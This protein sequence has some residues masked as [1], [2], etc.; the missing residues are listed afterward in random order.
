MSE[1]KSSGFNPESWVEASVL[2][3]LA[4]EDHPLAKTFLVQ[5][6]NELLVSHALNRAAWCDVTAMAHLFGLF[7]AHLLAKSDAVKLHVSHQQ[8]DTCSI[9]EVTCIQ[10][11]TRIYIHLHDTPFMLDTVRNYLKQSKLTIYAQAHTTVH[12]KR[13]RTGEPVALAQ[14]DTKGY[15]REMVI[16]IL[17]ETV[18]DKHLEQI[19]DELQAVLTSVKRSVD[20]F[21]AMQQQVLAQALLLD[22]E[23]LTE[24]ASFFRWMADENF[25]FMGT[26]SIIASGEQLVVDQAVPSFGVL[27]GHDSTALLDRIMPGM[28]QEIEK[29][30]NLL[31][32]RH[33]QDPHPKLAIEYC[34]HG[35][36]IIYAAEGVDFVVL[37]RPANPNQATLVLTLILG[38]FSRTGLAS[39]ASNVPILSRRLEKTLQLSGFTEG[40]YLHHEFRS[41]YDRMPLRELLYSNSPVITEQIKEIL[42]MEGDNDVR[43]LARLGH[44]G[45]YVAVLTT[46]ARSRYHP[47]LQT[48]IAELYSK[49]LDFPI[50]SINST[51]NGT[52][53]TVVCY[54]NHEPDKPFGFNRTAI[55]AQVR[56]LVMTWEDH[57]REELLT[58]Y[59][60][61][62]AFQLCTR[63]S[64]TF[65]ILYKEATPA[66]QAVLDIEMLEKLVEGS[67]FTSRIAHYP[68][69]QVY[70]KLYAHKPAMLTKIVQTFDNFGISCL[71]EFSTEVMLEA[72]KPLTIQ[73]FEVGGSSAQISALLNRAELFCEALNAVQEDAIL[74]DKLN[75]LVLIQGFH[76]KEVM[77][78]E[79]LRQ[80]L[81]QIRP[82]LSTK[83][84]NRVLLEH[85]PLTKRIL[86][87]FIARFDPVGERGRKKRIKEILDGLEEGL[88][89]VANL[90]DDQVIRALTN[91]VTSALRTNFYQQR[92]CHGISF[93]VDCSA[94][95]QMPSPRPWREIFVLSPHM[96]GVHLRGGRVARGGLRFSDRLEDF[97]TEILGLMKTQM[98][99]N[100]IIVPIGAKGGFIVPRIADIPANQRK[101]WV[102]NQYKT[103]IRGLLDI[104]DNRVE[105]ELVYPEQVVRYDEADPYLVVAAD[106]GT[107]TFSDIANGVAEQEYHFWLG[108]AF[109]SGGSYGYDHKKVGITARGAWTCI[110]QHF[111]ELG[112]DIDSQP[113]TVVGIGDMS[114]DVFGNGL[115]AS[116]QIKMVGAFNH[117]HIFLDP[118]PDPASSFEERQRLFNLGR[119][120]WNDYNGALISTGGGI[121][122]RSAKAIPLND[123]L[124]NLLDTKSETL[125]GEQVIQKLL[126][127][128]VDLIY[129]GGIGTYVKSRYETH[130]DVSDK[131]NDSVRVD[132]HQMRCRIIGEG[133]NL[134]VTQKGRLEFAMNK[135]RIN[136]DAVDN[137]GGV[138]LS[139]H[140]VNLK[141]LFAHLEQIGELPSRQARNEL[142][143]HLTEQV[144]EKVLEDNHLQ[145]MA[146]SRDELLSGQSPEIYLEGLDILE[147]VAGLDADEEDVPQREQLVEYLE[148]HPMPRPLLAIMLGYTKLFAYRELLKSDVVDLFFFERYLVDYFPDLV[149]RDYAQELTKH[150]LKREVIATSVTN[151]VVN[152]T[153]VGPLLATYNKVRRSRL[154][155]PPLPILFKAYVIAENMVDAPAFRAQVHG[156]GGR[157]S[158]SVKYQVLADMEGVLLHL[159]AWMLTHLSSDR[160]TVDVIN[161]YGKVIGA[162]QGRLWDSL[163]EL[164]AGEQ[165]NELIKRRKQ[166]VKMGL[167]ESLATDTV[168]LP[169]MKDAMTILHIKEA[170][171]V[172]FEPVGHLYI[173]VDDF[174]GISWIE[175]NL[176]Q[177]RHRDIWGRMNLENVRKELWET[178]T[179]LV[180]KIISFKRQNESVGDAFQS[181]INE[182]SGAN[183]EYM[184]L[185]S[186]LKAQSKHDLLP[187]SVLVR[188]LREMLLHE[189]E[190]EY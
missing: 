61:R 112:H 159:A 135:G 55:E 129:N 53:H 88:Q 173:R 93:K 123:T 107:A 54:A 166:L 157:L 48:Q 99:K 110:R 109:A 176:Q 11:G 174:F 7:Q 46:L 141:I 33:G 119:S 120:G 31:V 22:G 126:L 160:I 101:E 85:H 38:R 82:E 138:D 84:L 27:R 177:I 67:S 117:L 79:A 81:L 113:F 76:P 121:F 172:P 64:S 100:S 34:E 103:L 35:R 2:P 87:L 183:K 163:P 20:D 146:M 77:L 49:Q 114:G 189:Q 80:Y 19:R 36:S 168:L 178:R 37:L 42:L 167:P 75:K 98:V 148:N 95:D 45:N 150:F 185:F 164:L 106:K 108:D 111:A 13:S 127:A 156:L 170:L 15:L 171:H 155:V 179:R 161:L 118:D 124:R 181:Y 89:G 47:R 17:S 187:L 14:T 137:S 139:D 10:E 29:I 122:N 74:D 151:R 134:G 97:R 142:L 144:A 62:L 140:E 188:K 128:K 90:Q 18:D 69:G 165:V 115:L 68:K 133:G 105:G 65:N 70:I 186:E 1:G 136:T 162:F 3:L 72:N 169:Y 32:K 83:K 71:H 182:V 59:A 154:D 125:S 28:R 180:K 94:I 51:D 60:P 147:E 4:K 102:E 78:M 190:E 25:V 26:R 16:L 63:Y 104:T 145:H 91:V 23:K 66:D 56:R 52:V 21:A 9:E 184:A 116:R 158:A 131:A 130:L 43:V 39:R 152:Q 58:K 132:A 92:G 40:S 41:L 143:A 30:L 24:E 73:R 8:H 149:A 175:E 44:Y 50:S 96:E 6:L 57:L 153:G 86:N 5:V 12:V